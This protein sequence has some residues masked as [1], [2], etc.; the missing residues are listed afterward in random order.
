MEL[1][2]GKEVEGIG[3]RAQSMGHRVKNSGQMT[4]V[5]EFS[6]EL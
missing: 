4:D 5:F 2:G 6:V 3:Q 1:R